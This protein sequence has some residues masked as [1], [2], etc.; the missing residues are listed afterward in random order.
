[1]SN[2]ADQSSPCELPPSIEEKPA[3]WASEDDNRLPRLCLIVAI[4]DLVFTVFRVP[5]VGFE[6][7]AAVG[8]TL[9]PAVAAKA[10]HIAGL[11]ML[12]VGIGLALILFGFTANIG[13][14][15]K[16][17]MAILYG[18]LNI[19]ATLA[20]IGV[21]LWQLYVFFSKTPSGSPQHPAAM[22]YGF[23]D[24]PLRVLYLGLYVT[25]VVTF[26]RWQKERSA[27]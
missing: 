23:I 4:V 11:A 16:Q 3:L 27:D 15:C 17:G 26:I 19:A 18:W 1:M 8:V 5:L 10:P 7:A 9:N 13:M 25:A 22:V 14:L 2:A 21:I 12:R 6:I 20:S 24:V